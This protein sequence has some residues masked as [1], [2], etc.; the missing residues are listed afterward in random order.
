MFNPAIDCP[1]IDNS[2][3]YHYGIITRRQY[4]LDTHTELKSAKTKRKVWNGKKWKWWS[5]RRESENIARPPQTKKG[6]STANG[7]KRN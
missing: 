6:T 2:H 7:L 4:A 1:N 5:E 3:K